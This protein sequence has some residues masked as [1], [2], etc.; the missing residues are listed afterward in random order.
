[1]R[2]SRLP[3]VREDLARVCRNLL[4][5][6]NWR[7]LS[8]ALFMRRL[9]W[10]AGVKVVVSKSL[11]V[12]SVSFVCLRFPC[13]SCAGIEALCKSAI[14]ISFEC[15]K[16]FFNSSRALGNISCRFLLLGDLHRCL[17]FRS[18]LLLS[19]AREHFSFGLF[20]QANLWYH[21]DTLDKWGLQQ[22]PIPSF[23]L[24]SFFGVSCWFC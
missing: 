3:Q 10:S 2:I 18:F 12:N 16:M 20:F 23:Q 13:S 1:M 22:Q 5:R 6:K 8:A 17:A 19:I 14:W 4:T 7:Y 11:V 9:T 15:E 21:T 24:H